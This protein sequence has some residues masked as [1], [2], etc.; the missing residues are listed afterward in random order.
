MWCQTDKGMKRESNQDTFLIDPELGLYV[1]ADGMG[2]HSG[3]E[4][5]SA[6]AV[7]VAR[8]V[9]QS[10]FKSDR[11]VY[12]HELIDRIYQEATK[13]IYAKSTED[14]SLEGMGT[15]MVVALNRDDT[16][17]IGNV[18][19]SR[20]YLLRGDKMWQLT[21]DHSL[22]NEHFR[23]GLLS[24]DK[25]DT[26]IHKNVITRSVGFDAGVDCDVV[27]RVLEADDRILMCSDG[28]SGMI[29]DEE[30][31]GIC[32]AE[33]PDL[34]VPKLIQTANEKGGED[35]VTALLLKAEL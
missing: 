14:K 12:P 11:G 35:N 20:A 4:V 10:S 6:M 29:S 7:Q 31:L 19:D 24:E 21:E 22:V 34:V 9:V 30:I 18:G 5:A 23:A 1:L 28:L 3:G 17:Y 32:N 8:E 2:G 33:E 16:L 13:R 15:T 26:F 25:M 27:E